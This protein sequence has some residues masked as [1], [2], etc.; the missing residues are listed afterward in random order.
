MWLKI[1]IFLGG[2]F[3][4]SFLLQADP[5][6]AITVAPAA[7]GRGGMVVADDPLAARVG[8]EVLKQGG[9]AVDAAVATAFALGVVE[10]EACGLG[11]GGFMLIYLAK[12]GKLIGI[13]YRAIA[14]R[15][16]KPDMFVVGGPG[17]SSH[18]EGPTTVEEQT[19]L[20][21]IGGSAVAVPRML[22]GMAVALRKYGSMNL[23]QILAPAIKL[24]EDGFPVSDTLYKSVL[25]YYS[26][27][28]K[29]PWMAKTFLNNGLPYEPGELMTMP[30]LGRSLRTIASDGPETFYRGNLA[31]AIVKGVQKHG[32][33]ISEEDLQSVRAS[34]CNPLV[35]SYRGFR[36]VTLPP[37]SSGGI[38]IQILNIL[39]GFNLSGCSLAERIHIMAEAYK[40]AFANR[41]EYLGDPAFVSVPIHAL[42]SKELGAKLRAW[43]D[44]RRASASPLPASLEGSETTHV[45]VID[46][47]G[48]I[49]SLTQSLNS[50]FGAKFL[51]PGTGILMNDTMAD[52]NPTPGKANS[53]APGKEPLSSMSPSFLFQRDEP[54]L[55]LGSAGA[56]RILAALVEVIVNVVDLHLS[57]KEAVDAPRFF[58]YTGNLY[59]EARFPKDV[60]EDL[61]E[62]GHPVYKKGAYDLYFGGVN[63]IQI[64][65]RGGFLSYIGVADPRRFGKAAGY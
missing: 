6:N 58:C 9:N 38:L 61:E 5:S 56:E 19:S 51:I 53:I 50:F 26:L 18:W 14:P 17:L 8:V 46:R 20:R 49:V 57:L 11:G 3:L 21:K 52:F 63:A 22:A 44:P 1:V 40:L 37:P 54:F 25:N 31:A 7:E 48:N 35:G 36:I 43:I 24:A 2:V 23:A 62:K 39:E 33:I 15:A 32:G 42:V 55:I 10:P 13:D 27:I 30:D 4:F 60:I 45:S 28:V 29:D 34:N 47:E 41:S 59:F 16:A 12:P 65:E 64:A